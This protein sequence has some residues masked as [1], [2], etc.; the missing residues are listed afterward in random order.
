M[1]LALGCTQA[2]CVFVPC[3]QLI[4]PINVLDELCHLSFVHPKPGTSRSLGAGLIPISSELCYHL[5]PSQ[6]T[7]CSMSIQRWAVPGPG[8]QGQEVGRLH[9]CPRPPGLLGLGRAS[10]LWTPD[11]L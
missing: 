8:E 11:H 5:G 3:L 10:L 2:F 6:I 1:T 9:P 7:M 4:H